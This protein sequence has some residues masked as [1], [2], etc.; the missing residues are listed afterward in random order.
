[1][2]EQQ[3]SNGKGYRVLTH[4]REEQP[5]VLIDN[6]LPD[7]EALV[8]EAGA[9]EFRQVGPYYP[10]VRAPARPDALAPA[11]ALLETALREVFGITTGVALVE[12]Y[13]SLVTTPPEALA[14]IQ[15]L[16]HF[17]TTDPGRIALLHYLCGPESG[18]TRFFRHRKTGYETITAERFPRYRDRLNA[19]AQASGVPPARYFSGDTEQFELLAAHEAKFNR[20]IIYRGITLHSGYIPED[21]SFSGDPARGRLTINTF[22][23][24]R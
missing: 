11:T 24:A 14:P 13:Y 2:N 16:P 7:A 1:M 12:C 15:R 18:G 6:F 19:E 9:L 8:R 5:V 23:Q 20:A 21:L 4:G 3:Q 10:G 17:D 22:M